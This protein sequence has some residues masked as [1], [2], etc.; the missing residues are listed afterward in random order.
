MLLL[1]FAL[2]CHEVAPADIPGDDPVQD[3]SPGGGDADGG[4]SIS[5]VED[6]ESADGTMPTAD[7]SMDAN[8][9]ANFPVDAVVD[10]G[11]R[12][13]A[14]TGEIQTGHDG[15]SLP[16]VDSMDLVAP[17]PAVRGYVMGAALGHQHTY[18]LRAADFAALAVGETVVVTSSEFVDPS[19]GNSH[20]HDIAFT[21]AAFE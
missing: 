3:S 7:A 9:D 11:A 16:E 2:A 8:M 13:V 20:T 21:C 1:G 15:H 17:H 10:T 12:C 14:V 19:T 18:I 5:P 4:M 6:G